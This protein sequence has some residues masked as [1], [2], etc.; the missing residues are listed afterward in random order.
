MARIRTLKP[1]FWQDEKLAPLDTL[2]R[3]VFIGL[4]SQADDAGRLV[5][6]VKL[7]DG[8]LFSQTSDTCAEALDTL[9]RLSRVLRYRSA[10]GQGIIQILKW[11]VHQKVDKPG[12]NILPPPTP[13]DLAT[14]G[15]V[16]PS[17]ESRE[18]LANVS[19]DP[20]RADLGS[21]TVEQLVVQSDVLPLRAQS[22]VD[23]DHL[24]TLAIRAANCGMADNPAI[25]QD[26]CRPILPQ[27]GDSRQIARDW[28]DAGYAWDAVMEEVYFGALEYKPDERHA[29]IS[30]LKY[31]QLRVRD[32][33]ES[34]ASRA[35]ARPV[36][37]RRRGSD[38]H[39]DAEV[40]SI[41]NEMP[42]A[43]RVHRPQ[44]RTVP[45][46]LARL[47]EEMKIKGFEVPVRAG[48]GG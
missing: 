7:I 26:R 18:T 47:M 8:L 20:P 2:T 36:R 14:A 42:G 39:P 19:R 34:D 41:R 16:E 1:E 40:N 22:D 31:F 13:E 25:D 10:S 23:P 38:I 11:E 30:T 24:I 5:D 9:A 35:I 27:H 21:G 32:R 45:F 3:L 12:K 15:V 44:E 48:A 29:Q 33:H 4:I 17:R 37:T 43:T 46:T 6:N 28:L